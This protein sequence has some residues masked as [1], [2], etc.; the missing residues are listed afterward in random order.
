MKKNTHAVLHD[1]LNP[2]QMS[3]YELR[4]QIRIQRIIPLLQ[5]DS[6]FCFV[7][8][9]VCKDIYLKKKINSLITVILFSLMDLLSILSYAHCT[10][11]S[12]TQMMEK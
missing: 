12:A 10:Y 3:V 4:L 7:T 8:S 9:W 6:V 2:K 11:N 5:R 1:L